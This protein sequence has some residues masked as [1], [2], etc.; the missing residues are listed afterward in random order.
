MSTP[1]RHVSEETINEI[2]KVIKRIVKNKKP[3]QKSTL[4]NIYKELINSFNSYS[5]STFNE[6]KVVDAAKKTDEIEDLRSEFRQIRDRTAF[7]FTTLQ[8]WCST[9]LKDSP[10]DT[11]LQKLAHPF[12]L[13][14]RIG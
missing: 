1:Q 2:K 14:N 12:V 13:T 3:R 4:I 10:K 7:A 8:Q 5:K 9:L 11:T 6:Y